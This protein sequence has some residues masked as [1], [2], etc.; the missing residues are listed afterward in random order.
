VRRFGG[1]DYRA[2]LQAVLRVQTSHPLRTLFGALILTGLAIFFTVT[3]LEFET[4]QSALITS[5][6]RLMQLLKKAEQ[7]SD[8]D[9]FIVAIRNK[10]TKGSLD[11]VRDL[12]PR[13]DADKKHFSQV[14]YRVDPARF[15][16]WALLYLK[17]KEI[18]R[19]SDNLTEHESFIRNF[20][21]SPGLVTFFQE[22]NN[23]MAASMVGHLFTG[24]LEPSPEKRGSGPRDLEFLLRMLRELKENVEGTSAFTSPWESFLLK[25]SLRREADEGYFW[26][27]GKKYLLLFVAPD[28]KGRGPT[29]AGDALAALRRNVQEARRRFPD[30]EAGV[31]GQKALDEDDKNLAL[32]DVSV[33]TIVSLAGLA[34][35]LLFFWRTVRRPLLQMTTQI[36]GLSLTFGLTTL[37][38]GHLNLLSVTFAPMVLGLGIDYDI[39]WFSRYNEERTRSD[40]SVRQALV[41]TMDKLGPSILLAALSTSLAFLPL[42]LTGFKGLAELGLICG[43]GLFVSSITTICL[44]PALITLFDKPSPHMPLFQ[45]GEEL[46]PLLR[47]TR[48]RALLILAV[49]TV[50]CG[51]SLWG[52]GKI[53]FDLNM[54]HLQS[55]DTESVVWETKLVEGSKYP[56][57]YG[58]LF[59]HSPDEIARK[60]KAL[61][62]LSTVSEVRSI[63][64][65]LPPDQCEK[66]PLLRR[67]KPVVAGIPPISVPPGPV[68][69]MLLDSVLSRIRFKMDDASAAEWGAGKP[70]EAQMKEARLLI[71]DIR[72][73]LRSDSSGLAQ[74]RL[75]RFETEMLKDLNDKVSL[76]RE[77]VNTRPMQVSDLPARVRERFVGPDSLSLIRVFPASNIWDPEYLGAFVRD[78]RSVDPDATGDPVT[79]YVFTREFRDSSIRAA[80]Y[81]LLLIALFLA[82]SQRSIVSA[83]V[84]I[85]PLVIGALLTFGLMH[86]FG[87][88]LNLAN[89]IFL[90]LVIGAGVEYGVIIVLRW[91]QAK[92]GEQRV[93]LPLSTGTGVL[94][95]GL[96][97]TIGFGSLMISRH[98]GIHSLGLLTTVGSLTVLA[99]ALIV[100]PALLLLLPGRK[101]GKTE[102]PAGQGQPPEGEH[103]KRRER[104]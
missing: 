65:F 81:A 103:E 52:A 60:I 37:F 53:K 87:I 78:L 14:F 92:A 20:S 22:V 70:L 75:K 77:N 2:A 17:P 41:N 19:L 67:M 68:D 9:A 64:N 39:H 31:T 66:L 79:L 100:L 61:E 47:I 42:S 102:A 13:L 21:R 49:T 58:V 29:A 35:L 88:D 3:R 40:Q 55:K 44:L 11:F 74:R 69:I 76:L 10:D 26:T 46:K 96:T 99:V 73:K 5:E 25:D 54:L 4:S 16:Q 98:Q 30:I 32:R 1:I 91:R 59:A 89:T 57:I 8:H 7:F 27:E 82:L 43:M 90:P 72:K 6:N 84:T 56:S 48:S 28:T 101:S 93:P 51:F 95:A 33:A 36:V 12:G 104:S 97:T 71:D 80:V 86:L 15:R 23:E 85:S 83:L 24:F 34:A 45:D 94:L 38:I 50:G 63:E 62:R 18:I